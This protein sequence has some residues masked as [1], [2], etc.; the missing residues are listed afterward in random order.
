[1]KGVFNGK[2]KSFNSNESLMHMLGKI[3]LFKLCEIQQEIVG[4][5]QKS[6]NCSYFKR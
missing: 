4:F 2:K 1:M 3:I 6:K 5:S